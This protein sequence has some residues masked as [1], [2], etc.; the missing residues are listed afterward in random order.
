MTDYERIGAEKAQ[1]HRDLDNM[2]P[3]GT[4]REQYDREWIEWSSRQKR[5]RR[6]IGARIAACDAALNAL[7]K[8]RA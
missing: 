4:H 6:T 7:L 5:Q 3:C 2:A 1:L 8:V